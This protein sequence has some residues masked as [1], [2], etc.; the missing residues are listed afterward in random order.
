[1]DIERFLWRCAQVP[2]LA[3]S[4]AFTAFVSK[5]QNFDEGMC[6]GAGVM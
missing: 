4:D 5:T 2:A 1:M 3:L 6:V